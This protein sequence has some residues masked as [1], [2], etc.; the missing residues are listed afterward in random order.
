MPCITFSGLS[1]APSI[2][3]SHDRA[4]GRAIYGESE[5][6][7]LRRLS[8]K[9]PGP[10][11][12]LPITYFAHKAGNGELTISCRDR[13]CPKCQAAASREWLAERE[14]EL[15]PVQYFHVVYTLPARIADGSADVW[16]DR[17]P[18]SLPALGANAHLAGSPIDIIQCKGRDLVGA[19]AELGQHHKNGV[20]PPPDGACSI[21][22]IEDILNLL[23]GQIGRQ[24]GEL[25]LPDRGH[26]A[27]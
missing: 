8:R 12:E 25:P 2:V 13:H 18:Y 9:V 19:Q 3:R 16:R 26:A 21:A 17:H 24:V 14:A 5:A 4:G 11:A 23:G 15:L 27:G 22:A 20:V 10:G 6:L 7:N 1:S